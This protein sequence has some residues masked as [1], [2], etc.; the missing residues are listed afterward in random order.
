MFSKFRLITGGLKLG[1]YGKGLNQQ[2]TK[3]SF[4][5]TVGK[6]FDGAAADRLSV[7]LFI[8]VYFTNLHVSPKTGRRCLR[9]PFT[10]RFPRFHSLPN[11]TFSAC[12]IES[13]CRRQN[14]CDSNTEICL[15]RDRKILGVKRVRGKPEKMLIKC[16]FSFSS[17]VFN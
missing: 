11:D 6:I 1:L 9:D 3:F 13:I 10:E 15:W 2:H 4:Q 16:N 5:D 12:Q 8:C 7:W 17:S 14:K